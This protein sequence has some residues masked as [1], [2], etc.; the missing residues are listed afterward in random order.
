MRPSGNGL[1]AAGL[2]VLL[3]G[4]ISAAAVSEIP[5]PS[6]VEQIAATA[7]AIRGD[8]LRHE[9]AYTMLSD[10]TRAAGPRLP[11]SPVAAKAVDHMRQLMEGL[12]LETW[13]EPTTVQHWIRGEELAR[14]VA[15][16]GAKEFELTI[17]ALGG[18]EPTPLGGIETRVIEVSS[19]EELELRSSAVRGAIVFFNHPMDRTLAD[20]FRAYGEAAAFRS[21]GPS[22]AARFGAVAALVRSLTFRIDDFPHT[23]MV[24]YDPALPKIP[25]AAVS[26]ED[27]ETL[28]S[29]LKK[30][31]DLRL[32][33]RLGC[34]NLDPVL[35]ANVVGQIRGT[36]RPDEVVLLG[37]H[38]DSWDLAVGAHDD[39]AGCIQAVE[40]LR[41][42]LRSGLKP[43]RTIRAVMFMN[44]EFGASGGRDYAA[45]P[46]RRKEKHL[47]AMESDRG[48]YLPLH[49]GIGGPP[50]VRKKW[51]AFETLFQE[52][53]VSG[54]R[55]GGG[56]SD[57]G[58][59]VTAGAVPMGFVPAAQAYFDVHHS[60]LDSLDKVHPRELEWGAILFAV[61]AVIASEE[62]I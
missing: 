35:T 49:I 22:R 1:F 30:H 39:G 33:L 3:V 28:S 12:G 57:I 14:I 42:I 37:G 25:A 55:S 23:G 61:M 36:E 40:A 46:R 38:L 31:P 20:A 59:I 48:G 21:E 5:S 26:T 17:S 9:A 58:P 34:A 19:F 50:E 51:G 53:G 54:I 44:E 52:L 47:V 13:T 45:D 41:L 8:G 16:A 11:G 29:Q 27:A 56:G 15:A 32:R 60:G 62:G 24:G 7:R 2:V 6:S 18:S 10:L 43:K 4:A